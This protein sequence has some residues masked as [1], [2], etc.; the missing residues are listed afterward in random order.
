HEPEPGVA[1]RQGVVAFAPGLDA[2]ERA[3]RL[4]E[5][6][7]ARSH[8][9]EDGLVRVGGDADALAGSQ[10]PGDGARRRVGLAS[11]GRTLDHQAATVHGRRHALGGVHLALTWQ[12]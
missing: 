3:A 6:L 5:R 8:E 12:P 11:A 2:Y 9:V 10:Q 1:L 7:P 4:R